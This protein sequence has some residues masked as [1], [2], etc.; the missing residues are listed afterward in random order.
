MSNG[1]PHHDPDDYFL[2]TRMSCGDH[3]EELRVHLWRAVYGFG[4]S[5][6]LALCVGHIVVEWIKAPVS[7][8]LD[9]FYKRRQKTVMGGLN[10][11]KS[12][13]TPRRRRSARS[14][15]SG[16]RSPPP[17]RANRPR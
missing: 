10:K 11:E 16:S 12:S 4:F 15:W 14:G 1:T 6:I 3:I 13:P 2:Q 17:T 7:Q 8:Q 5:M 9:E